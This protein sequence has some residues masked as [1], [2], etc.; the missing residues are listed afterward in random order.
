MSSSKDQ[1]RQVSPLA[2]QP[3]QPAMLIDVAKLV[4][5]YYTG[6]PDP[7]APGQRVARG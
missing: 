2:G 4:T 5:A 3:A 1:A 6:I 7:S